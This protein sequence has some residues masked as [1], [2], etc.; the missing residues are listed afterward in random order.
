MENKNISN[1][2][3]NAVLKL[4]LIGFGVFIFLKLNIVIIYFIVAAIISLIGRP[5]VIFLEQKLKFR[6]LFAALFTLL[7][8]VGLIFGL[9]SLIIP[10]IVKQGESLSLLNLKALESNF[11]QLMIEISNYFNLDGL[12]GSRNLNS[13]LNIENLEAIP[14]FL[15]YLLSLLGSFTVGLFSVMFI[16]FFLLKDSRILEN[17]ILLLVNDKNQEKLE[18][19]IEKIK[20][21]LSRYFLGLL[22]Q[23][24]ILLVFYTIVLSVFS[25]ENAFVIAFLCALLNLIPYIGPVI[26]IFLMMFLTMTSNI[27]ADFSTVILPKTLYVLIGFTI[28]QII[29]NIF[30]QPYI[31]SNS[32]KSHPLEIFIV[33]LA[34]GTL[35]GTTGMIV[36]IPLYTS[37]KVILK[38]FLFDNKIVKSITKDI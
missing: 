1:S 17:T 18:N 11:N 5:I 22:L 15:N 16:S 26:G 8:L 38:E 27:G 25:I 19:S 34:G 36:A 3:V 10:L 32:V 21:L 7:F 2:I 13:L 28:G 30:S 12:S 23:I 35:L 14:N 29:D 24:S 37:L 9:I 33:I 4:S 6:K 20:N 31:F